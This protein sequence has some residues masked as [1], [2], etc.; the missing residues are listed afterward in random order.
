MLFVLSTLGSNLAVF[1]FADE[2]L[3][4]HTVLQPGSHPS[5]GAGAGT[6][7]P[8]QGYERPIPAAMQPAHQR[9]WPC[10]ACCEYLE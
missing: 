3:P 5:Q 10:M 9:G 1:V 8:N 6:L 7:R 2:G 4:G